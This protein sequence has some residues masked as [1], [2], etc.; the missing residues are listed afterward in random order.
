MVKLWIN[1]EQDALESFFHYMVCVTLNGINEKKKCFA[2]N[3][4]GIKIL[5]DHSCMSIY[6]LFNI[7]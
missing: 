1:F 3:K 6:A 7:V 5:F 2:K 4:K